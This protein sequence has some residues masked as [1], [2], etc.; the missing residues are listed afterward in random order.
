MPISSEANWVLSPMLVG[1]P[2]VGRTGRHGCRPRRSCGLPA[3]E[4]RGLGAGVVA[5]AVAV[6]PGLVERQPAEDVD[7]VLEGLQWLECGRQFA[8]RLRFRCP[9]RHVHAVGDV[10][11]CRPDGALWSEPRRATGVIASSQGKATAAPRPLRTVR[12]VIGCDMDCQTP[13]AKTR[14]AAGN[15]QVVTMRKYTIFDTRAAINKRTTNHMDEKS[16][17]SVCVHSPGF[18]DRTRVARRS[19]S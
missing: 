19:A 12:R 16:I 15:R 9:G 10:E 17:N 1:D 8:E 18:G 14:H 11:E 4:E 13:L 2:L 6:G 7:V 5:G 3:G